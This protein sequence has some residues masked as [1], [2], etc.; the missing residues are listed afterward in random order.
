M[1]PRALP[2]ALHFA[3][4]PAR[5][6]LARVY[7]GWLLCEVHTLET[8][9]PCAN[10]KF[11]LPPRFLRA[12]FSQIGMKKNVGPIFK[13]LFQRWRTRGR[14]IPSRFWCQKN[15]QH[16]CVVRI[17]TN[18]IRR[19]GWRVA[20]HERLSR[21]VIRISAKSLTRTRWQSDN[22]S[23]AVTHVLDAKDVVM[24][25]GPSFLISTK[26]WPYP[27]KYLFYLT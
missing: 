7:V 18:I 12:R 11:E 10:R 20:R 4:P 27:A 21:C 16:P 25:E 26:Y 3:L 8:V 22:K 2:P 9:P 14:A 15:I 23:L 13:S 6:N 5:I 19:K 1:Q 24:C 17:S